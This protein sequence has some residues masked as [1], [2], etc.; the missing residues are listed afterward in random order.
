MAG[1]VTRCALPPSV[2]LYMGIS[3]RQEPPEALQMAPS[4]PASETWR[5][6][7]E[8]VRME[9]SIRLRTYGETKRNVLG[10]GGKREHRAKESVVASQRAAGPALAVRERG[11]MGPLS[12][13]LDVVGGFAEQLPSGRKPN[14]RLRRHGA[15][16]RVSGHVSQV[17]RATRIHWVSARSPHRDL[18]AQSL[19]NHAKQG[20]LKQVRVLSLEP[21]LRPSQELEGLFC[22]Y[23]VGRGRTRTDGVLAPFDGL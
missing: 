2:R 5:H 20:G 23:S 21:T 19:L 16:P 12:E 9:H 10:C 8:Q 17:D 15:H 11:E 18:S 3:A 6:R 4:V 14:P 7:R 22:F 13:V 1:Q